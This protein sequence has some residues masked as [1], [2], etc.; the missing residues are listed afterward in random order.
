M[1][2]SLDVPSIEV[3][4]NCS[5]TT[6]MKNNQSSAVFANERNLV[7]TLLTLQELTDTLK[8]KE[9][10]VYQRIHAQ[11]LP[12]AYT[13]VGRYLRFPAAGVRAYL[14]SQ[15]RGGSAA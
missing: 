2:S 15:M 6:S 12:F 14:E 1:A 4:R 9:G 5:Q 13:K 8:I 7:G 3:K 11:N 10:W